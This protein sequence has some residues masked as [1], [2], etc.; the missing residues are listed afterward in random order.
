MHV[1][2]LTGPIGVGK[3]TTARA[4]A[5][6]HGFHC[7]SFAQGIRAV[8]YA[9]LPPHTPVAGPTR[10]KQEPY[11]TPIQLTERALQ[12]AM[13][14]IEDATLLAPLLD[15]VPELPPVRT[16]RELLQRVGDFGRAAFGP[17]VWLV[18]LESELRSLPN[19]PDCRVVIDDV[20]F[21]AEVEWIYSCQGV[22]IRLLPPVAGSDDPHISEHDLDGIEVDAVIHH[23]HTNPPRR[24]AALVYDQAMD[25]LCQHL[26]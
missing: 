4:I 14:E 18:L 11:P 15:A 8:A 24:N 6:E 5:L 19:Y 2:G 9:M 23:P 3:T 12:T 25:L 26:T 22:V 1:I 10:N 17:T 21:R 16:E 7:L 20:R 13:R